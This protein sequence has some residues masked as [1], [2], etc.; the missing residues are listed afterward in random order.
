MLVSEQFDR[1]V[2]PIEGRFRQDEV[3]GW[4]REAGLEVVVVLPGLGWRAIGRKPQATV[5]STM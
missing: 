5:G 3:E 2:A 4:L 1:F